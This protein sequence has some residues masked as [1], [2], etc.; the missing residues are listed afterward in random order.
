MPKEVCVIIPNFNG[1][2]YLESCIRALKQQTFSDF[3]LLVVDNASTDES[4]RWLKENKIET[5]FSDRNL[6]FAGG[7][8]LGLARARS[9]Y[10]ILLNNDTVVFPDF[11]ERL[12][13]AVKASEEIFA[14]NPM[15]RRADAPDIID[16]AGDGMCLFG[17]AYQIGVGEHRKGFEREREVFSAC[18]GASIY[19]KEVLDRIGYFDEAF[20]AY[21]EDMDVSW[22]A[23]LFGYQ[24]RYEPG[25]RVYHVGSATSGS[26]YNPF[27][28]R[29]AARNN[30]YLHYKNQH[31]LQLLV[32]FIPLFLGMVI[33]TVFFWRKGFLEDYAAG[34]GEGLK[35]C[36]RLRRE[37]AGSIP[38]KRYW[39]IQW[40]MFEGIFEYIEHFFRRRFGNLRTS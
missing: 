27:K 11:V 40:A 6:G 2:A 15:M 24:V 8:N 21:L 36:R 32:N 13:S 28:V 35:T 12:V 30:I 17:W 33:K 19:R 16:D 38:L 9:P 14:V 26:K 18:G 5:I 4:R 31:T 1:F 7:I 20:F 3:D 39:M 22:R 37:A 34:I 10:V 25:A 29:L 23:R